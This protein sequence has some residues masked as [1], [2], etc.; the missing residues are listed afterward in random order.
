M[1]DNAREEFERNCIEN[2]FRY[3]DLKKDIIDHDYENG[4]IAAR[5]RGWQAG[6]KSQSARIAELEAQRDD[7]QALCRELVE[8]AESYLGAADPCTQYGFE[9]ENKLIDTLNKARG[10]L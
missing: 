9:I 6:I 4:W 2:G 5:W 1:T 7:L 3:F 8:A 10:K